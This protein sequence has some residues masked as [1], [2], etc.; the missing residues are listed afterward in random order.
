MR[1]SAFI[2]SVMLAATTLAGCA[3]EA[4]VATAPDAPVPKKSSLTRSEAA[5]QCW[6]AAEKGRKDLP[7]DKRADVVTK[8]ID[9]KLNAAEASPAG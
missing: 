9:D 6:M 2:V 1:H 7:L 8:C 3:S 4:K 5:K